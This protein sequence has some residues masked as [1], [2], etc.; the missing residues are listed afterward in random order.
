[1]THAFT[2]LLVGDV[3][4]QAKASQTDPDRI[5]SKSKNMA[6]MQSITFNVVE[7][8]KGINKSEQLIN[9]NGYAGDGGTAQTNLTCSFRLTRNKQVMM[10]TN[11]D[12]TRSR[13]RSNYIKGLLR[14]VSEEA[15]GMNADYSP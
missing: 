8:R 12:D 13:N 5:C 10:A 7:Q 15:Y 14:R 11:V 3:R 2:T 1:M 4:M 9:N 6:P